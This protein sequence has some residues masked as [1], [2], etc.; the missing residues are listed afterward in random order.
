VP[1]RIAFDMDG[2]LA[3][4]DGALLRHAKALFGADA[5][6]AMAPVTPAPAANAVG[7]ASRTA[8]PPPIQP[9]LPRLRRCG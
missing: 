1:L 8:R 9:T 2:V 7:P 5:V 6:R 4:M 3:D